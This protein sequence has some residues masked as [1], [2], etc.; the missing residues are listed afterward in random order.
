MADFFVWVT[1]TT[2]ASA[3]GL[4]AA[5]VREAYAV[6]PLAGSG[7]LTLDGEL[8]SLIA[9][10]LSKPFKDEKGP[11][12]E[13]LAAVKRAYTKM[14][15]TYHSIIVSHIGGTCQWTGSNITLPKPA[16]KTAYDRLTE[17]EHGDEKKEE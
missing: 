11:Q 13:V 2:A 1:S 9:L 10:K 7:D 4:V 17:D 5:L 6:S 15:A 16:V 14:G 3:D 12:K 8:S